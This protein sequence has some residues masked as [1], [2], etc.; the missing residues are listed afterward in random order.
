MTT[1]A[2]VSARLLCAVYLAGLPLY[3]APVA[4]A[5]TPPPIDDSRLPSPATPA[6]PQRTEQQEQCATASG[7][8]VEIGNSQLDDL[9]L[10]SIWKLTRGAGQT[11]AVIDTGVARHRLLPHLVPGGDYV[12]TGD[13]TDDCDGHGTMVAGIIGAAGPRRATFS[14]IAPD[15]TIIGIRQSSN[16]FRA[17]RMIPRVRVSVMST[18]LPWPCA[19]RPTWARR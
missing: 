12:S 15:A 1:I 7:D 2:S 3:T 4:T 8:S 13:G 11:V 10:T 5:V 17:D 16:M 6:P 19:R 14:G 9:G 18:P